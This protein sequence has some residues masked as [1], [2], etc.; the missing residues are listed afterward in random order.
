M[1][2]TDNRD[3]V[4]QQRV[5]PPHVDRRRALEAGVGPVAKHAIAQRN[6]VAHVAIDAHRVFMG[7]VYRHNVLCLR[8]RS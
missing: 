7:G 6:V 3:V 2:R 1:W 5:S 8:Q 4:K